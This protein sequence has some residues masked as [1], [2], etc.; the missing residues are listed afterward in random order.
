MEIFFQPMTSQAENDFL[1]LV[2][3]GCIRTKIASETVERQSMQCNY[4]S[5]HT[6]FDFER[7]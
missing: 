2:V 3:F 4:L 1:R 5:G 6:F 7:S